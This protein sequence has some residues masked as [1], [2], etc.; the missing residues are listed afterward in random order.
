MGMWSAPFTCPLLHSACER[1]SRRT[2]AGVAAAVVVGVVD[3]CSSPLIMLAP[4]GVVVAWGY[5]TARA[6]AGVTRGE[7]PVFVRKTGG[8]R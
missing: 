5:R 1:T 4:P 7:K 6:C 2:G 3:C 8:Y